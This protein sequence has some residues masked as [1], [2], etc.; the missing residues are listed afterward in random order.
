MQGRGYI[1]VNSFLQLRRNFL[2]EFC[3]LAQPAACRCHFRSLFF[4][5]A[6]EVPRS[7]NGEESLSLWARM[8]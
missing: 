7:P 4:T 1:D 8:A 6:A 3:C 5:T 2:T